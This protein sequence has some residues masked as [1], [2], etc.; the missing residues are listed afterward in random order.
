MNCFFCENPLALIV[1]DCLKPCHS[2]ICRNHNVYHQFVNNS[3]VDVSFN[4]TLAYEKYVIYYVETIKQCKIYGEKNQTIC[5]FTYP[6]IKLT[7]FNVKKK[8]PLFL[9]FS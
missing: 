6:P 4:C 8:L 9:V 3:L 1:A 7:P 2:E 5:K